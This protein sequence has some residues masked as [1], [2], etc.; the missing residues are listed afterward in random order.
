MTL[1]SCPVANLSNLFARLRWELPLKILVMVSSSYI[2]AILSV[3]TQA[4]A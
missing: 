1:A 3:R 2:R 4:I